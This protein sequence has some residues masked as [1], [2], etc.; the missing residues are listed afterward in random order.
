MLE[1]S[2]VSSSSRLVIPPAQSLCPALR[3]WGLR[4]RSVD[5]SAT[6]LFAGSTSSETESLSYTHTKD[7]DMAGHT[8]GHRQGT[9]SSSTHT[10]DS[11]QTQAHTATSPPP[12]LGLAEAEGHQCS[13]HTTLSRF[14]GTHTFTGPPSTGTAPL[15]T[16]H[17]A[18]MP[19]PL[20]KP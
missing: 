1:A 7:T 6:F 10:E 15:P 17:P 8:D 18:W 14:T 20:P 3:P 11:H 13:A 19:A 9:A 5:A 16:Q 4:P 2:A 12:P